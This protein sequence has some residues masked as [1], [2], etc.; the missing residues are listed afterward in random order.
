MAVRSGVTGGDLIQ[1]RLKNIQRNLGHAVEKAMDLNAEDLLSRSQALCPQKTSELL[2]DAKI[3][4]KDPSGK[5]G[6][7]FDRII[8]YGNTEPSSKYALFIHEDTDYELGPI[9]RAKPP[10]ADGP[11]GR[12][13]LSRPYDIHRRRYLKEIGR[14]TELSIQRSIR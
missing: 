5:R 14:I 6:G 11:V 8:S 2:G 4:K 10:T 13:F 12:K 9:S 1:K 3:T 7:V